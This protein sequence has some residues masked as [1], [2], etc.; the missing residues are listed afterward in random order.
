MRL[1]SC[2]LT[3][4]F[5]FTIHS[6]LFTIHYSLRRLSRAFFF[7]WLRPK[8]RYASALR[9]AD[10]G[11]EKRYLRYRLTNRL[12]AAFHSPRRQRSGES[13]VRKLAADDRESYKHTTREDTRLAPRPIAQALPRHSSRKARLFLTS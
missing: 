6:S 12:C 8:F 11:Y 10:E 3:I 9:F 7:F 1:V 13:L 2:F 5:S 4:H